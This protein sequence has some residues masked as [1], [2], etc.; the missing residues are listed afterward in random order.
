MNESLSR[1]FSNEQKATLL[2]LS[3]DKKKKF[4]DELSVCSKRFQDASCT[5]LEEIAEILIDRYKKIYTDSNNEKIKLIEE[6]EKVVFDDI[7]RLEEAGNKVTKAIGGLPESA[8]Y[9][10]CMYEVIGVYG[11]ALLWLYV[12]FNYGLYQSYQSKK[13]AYRLL[14]LLNSVE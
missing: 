10:S 7:N 12:S 3:E 1:L 13:E 14:N 6:Q 2:D 11:V 9:L 4:Y 5:Q 8:R